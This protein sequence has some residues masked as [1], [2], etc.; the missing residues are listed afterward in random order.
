M[1]VTVKLQFAVW[2]EV[3]V[4]VQ[5]TVVTPFGNAEPDGGLQPTVTP[6]QL[7][8]A[9]GV[10]YVTTVEHN[11]GAVLVTIGDGHAPIVGD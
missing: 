1:T 7:S 3:S 10:A 11:P 8:L 4:A 5:V 2:L 6:G 9:L